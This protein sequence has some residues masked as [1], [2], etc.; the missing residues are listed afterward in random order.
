MSVKKPSESE[1]EFFSRQEAEKLKK[2]ALEKHR[3]IAANDREKAKQLHYMHCPKC[4][5]DLH[6]VRYKSM[7]V[8]RCFVCG[9]TW[10]D[11]GELEKLAGKE[12]GFLKGLIELFK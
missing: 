6:T 12:P 9:G 1:D 10:L 2:A 11:Q 4:G 3:E 7:P 5:N 8:E